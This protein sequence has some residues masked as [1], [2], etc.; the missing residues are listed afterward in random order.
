M[1]IKCNKLTCNLYDKN[2]YVV[3]I[4][5]LK[6]TLNHGLILRKN[7]RVIQ[8]NPS[9]FFVLKFPGMHILTP[10][11]VTFPKISY[12]PRKKTVS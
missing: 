5:S 8:F 7:N 4:R 9:V 3:H 10:N 2:N 12:Y 1:K 6:Q 11:W